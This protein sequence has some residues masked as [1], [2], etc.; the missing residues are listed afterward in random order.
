MLI[1]ESNDPEFD[2]YRHRFE[3]IE[4]AT[5]KLLK[6]SKAYTDAVTNLFTNA[7]DFGAHF[8]TVF[9]PLGGEYGLES[10]HPDAEHT[11]ANVDGYA[12]SLEDL[13]SAVVPEL[14][15]IESRVVGPIK[16]FQGILKAIRKSITKRDHKVR[17]Y[18]GSNKSW[19]VRN[20]ECWWTGSCVSTRIWRWMCC[21]GR[22][23][24]GRINFNDINT[25][26]SW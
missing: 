8:A 10:K 18:L 9:H 6:D 21:V 25:L 3:S 15:L 1:L 23:D 17:V 2:D 20:K 22:H 11:I 19:D 12:A 4:K 26:F 13:K 5:E 7:V 14:E 16:E 24:L